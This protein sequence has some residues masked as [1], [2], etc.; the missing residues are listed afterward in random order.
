MTTI[1]VTGVGVRD[2]GGR[3]LRHPR[4]PGGG[5]ERSEVELRAGLRTAQCLAVQVAPHRPG[6]GVDHQE[7]AV[8]EPRGVEGQRLTG[9]DGVEADPGRADDSEGDEVRIPAERVVRHVVVRHHEQRIG[10]RNAVLHR[11]EHEVVGFHPRRDRP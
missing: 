2:G 1:L 10:A 8:V 4:A 9:D 3:I 11:A 5:L 6:L 7:D